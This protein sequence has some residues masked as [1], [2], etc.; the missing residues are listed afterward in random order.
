MPKLAQRLTF[1]QIETAKPGATLSAG[2]GLTLIVD[3]SGN[4]RWIY[5]YTR[6]DGRRNAIG[7]G[8]WPVVSLADAQTR[9]FA[10]KQE[11]AKGNDPS[12]VKKALKLEK[13]SKARNLFSQIAD[14]WLN[15]KSAGWSSE[16]KRKA[17]LVLNNYLKLDL[18]SKSIAD[19]K[20]SE[21][22]V[23]LLNIYEKAPDLAVKARQYLNQ[24]VSY[25]MQEDLRED[26]R[27]LNLGNILPKNRRSSHYPA[28]TKVQ[29][30]YTLMTCVN[31][32]DSILTKTAIWT[33]IYTACRPG[34]AAGM[35]WDEIDFEHREWHVSSRRMKM[36]FD[37][38]SPIPSQLI[39]M[40]KLIRQLLLNDEFVFPSAQNN[41]HISRD[42]LSKA[43]R[44]HGLKGIAVTHGC[45]ATFR[46]VARE[47]L[48]ANEDVLEAQLAHAKKGQIQ[49]AYDRTDLLDERRVLIQRWADYL[50]ELERK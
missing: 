38:I 13:K 6:P 47:R 14:D 9:T 26:G 41:K 48:G 12:D 3:K 31:T 21:A 7:M 19:I 33:C 42:T 25:A 40:L 44:D 27:F 1:K 46:T 39:D 4:K 20:S 49:A 37:H 18:G 10:F 43:M 8:S 34:I 30:L 15:S 11:V 32:I 17:E 28:I 23:A 29:Q 36:D 45:R 35:R 2:N 16:T 24:I 50:G 22:K 5:R